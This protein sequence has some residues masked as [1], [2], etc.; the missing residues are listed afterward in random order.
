[1][2]VKLNDKEKNFTKAATFE[3]PGKSDCN[4]NT[5]EKLKEKMDK[6]RLNSVEKINP[7]RPDL[8]PKSKASGRKLIEPNLKEGLK[9]ALLDD[10]CKLS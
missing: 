9:S 8:S 7:L 5:V 2:L 3:Q 6:S 10:D 4:A 1:M